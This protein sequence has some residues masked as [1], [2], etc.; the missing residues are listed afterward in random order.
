M[1][2]TTLHHSQFHRFLFFCYVLLDY[3]LL[4]HVPPFIIVNFIKSFVTR[5]Y[6]FPTSFDNINHSQ[7]WVV[8]YCLTHS[9]SCHLRRSA[10]RGNFCARLKA[11]WASAP[12]STSRRA[13]WAAWFSPAFREVPSGYVKI[14]IEM[15][16]YS[17][18]S[19]EKWWFSIVTLPEGRK[20][21]P[22]YLFFLPRL[23][24]L[25]RVLFSKGYSD[26]FSHLD[27][28]DIVFHGCCPGYP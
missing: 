10:E 6:C 8:Y 20:A 28:L 19:H 12:R 27:S 24:V 5:K 21:L 2:S 4:D 16:I 9:T 15:A 25:S 26:L 11:A 14:A 1:W 7:S 17:G 18:F 23:F 22:G 13:T 3:V